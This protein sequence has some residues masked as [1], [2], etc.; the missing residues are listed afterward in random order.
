MT[1]HR[2]I[3]LIDAPD[4]YDLGPLEHRITELVAA[5]KGEEPTE[6]TVPDDMVCHEINVCIWQE[7][8]P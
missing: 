1:T 7:N 6:E 5:L 8:Q 4:D 2:L 3:V